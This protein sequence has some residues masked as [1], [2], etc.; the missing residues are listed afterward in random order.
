MTRSASSTIKFGLSVLIALFLPVAALHGQDFSWARGLGGTQDDGGYDVTTDAAGNVYVTGY[1]GGTVDFDPGAGVANMTSAGE[2]DV[3]VLKLDSAG[4]F[5][6]VRQLGGSNSER[7]LNVTVDAAGNIYTTGWFEG[8]ADFDPGA[9]IANL[10]STGE[11]NAFISKL[12]SSGNFVWAKALKGTGYSQGDDVA[13]DAGGNVYSAGYF[14]GSVDFDP[15]SGVAS[16]TPAGNEDVYVSKLDSAGN[17]VWARRIGGSDYDWANGLALDANSN[18]YTTGVFGGTVDFDPGAGGANLTSAGDNDIFVLK[19]DSAGAFVWARQLGGSDSDGG[20]QVAVDAGG[21]VYTTGWFAATADFDPGGGVAN[22]AS[23]GEFNAFISKLDSGGDFVWAK[24]LKGTGYSQGDDVAVDAGGNV[25]TAGYFSGS[26]DFDPGSGVASLTPAGNEDV[27]VSKLDSA[28]NFVWARRMGGPEYDWATNIALDGDGNIYTSGVFGGTVDFDPGA[29]VFNLTSSGGDDIFISKLS[30]GPGGLQP[31]ISSG[32]IVV[33]NLLPTVNTVS[34]LSIISVFGENF[35]TETILY[36]N[37]TGDGKLA[38]TLGDAC[39]MMNGEALPIF[40]V[41]PGQIN[42][43]VSA[44]KA[45]GPASFTVVANCGSAAAL[46]SAPLS[47]ES[48]APRNL[49]SGVEMVTVEATT[50]AFF[51]FN[52]VAA[53]GFI[54]ARFNATATQAAVAVA[55]AGM[56]NDQYGPSRPASPGD[57]ILLYGTGWGETTAGLTTGELAS[58]AAQV[59]LPE[60]SPKI[61]LGGIQLA[62]EDLIYVGVTPGTAGLYQAAIRIP[63]NA[64]AGNQQVVLTVYGKST[65]VGPVIPIALP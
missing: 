41:T 32:G 48:P 49:T 57:I 28:G 17:F 25:Y 15:G 36:P 5:V 16:L 26:V 55:P 50:P 3:F 60:A 11:F 1:F 29:D 12:D 63:A 45:F 38:T 34:P 53:N 9:G 24:A 10:A 65:P 40:A 51:I 61:T 47:L 35:S 23:T 59:L 8:T 54:A 7:S 14:S 20:L 52:P 42:A 27:Y 13:V 37:L 46:T 43:Q 62:A 56:F 2:D 39:L 44:N 4:A 33:A 64:Q 6:W 58:A 30:G 18:V 31:V 19:L 21:S 22:L